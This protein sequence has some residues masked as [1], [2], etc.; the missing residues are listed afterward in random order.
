MVDFINQQDTISPKQ[1]YLDTLYNGPNQQRLQ[2]Y[3]DYKI[4][5]LHN[6]N[7]LHI[8]L[9]DKY[10]RTAI[11]TML[12]NRYKQVLIQYN[13]Y[14]KRRSNGGQR[15]LFINKAHAYYYIEHIQAT[16]LVDGAWLYNTVKN[17]SSYTSQILRKIYIEECGEGSKH[18][19]HVILYKQLLNKYNLNN[20]LYQY[21]EELFEQGSIQLALGYVDVDV[22]QQ[23]YLPYIIGYN[24]GYEQL[25]YHLLVETYELDELGIDNYYF[26]LHVTI[27]NSSNGHAAQ[28]IDSV[29]SYLDT[30]TDINIREKTI[31][32]NT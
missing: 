27:D 16:K 10:D 9:P 32:K 24:L 20:N 8:D 31:S 1:L 7:D 26:Q 5:S 3:L 22:E 17:C 18:M 19:N 21:N 13:N 30:Y 23:D 2:Q 29:H 28:A 14:L 25:P 11:Q 6:R 4:L 15:E 12:S